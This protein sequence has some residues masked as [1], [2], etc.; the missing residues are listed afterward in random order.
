M[1]YTQ[2]TAVRRVVFA[3]APTRDVVE[4]LMATYSDLQAPF[5]AS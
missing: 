4:L 3:A 1:A 5:D 2:H